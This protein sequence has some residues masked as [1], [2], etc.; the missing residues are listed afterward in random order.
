MAVMDILGKAMGKDEAQQ[1]KNLKYRV[2]KKIKDKFYMILA[3]TMIPGALIMFVIIMVIGMADFGVKTT[4]EA[5]ILAVRGT[6]D[7]SEASSMDLLKDVKGKDGVFSSDIVE[8]FANIGLKIVNG[9]EKLVFNLI[10][11]LANAVGDAAGDSGGSAI[12]IKFLHIWEEHEGI[13]NNCYVV[14]NVKGNATV[15]YGVDLETSGVKPKVQAAGYGTTDGSLIPI[16]FVDKLELEERTSNRQYVINKTKGLGLKDYQIDALCAITYQCGNIG[17]F[18]SAYKKYGNTDALKSAFWTYDRH[19]NKCKQ[20]FIKLPGDGRAEANWILFHTGKYTDKNKKEI[21]VNVG[22]AKTYNGGKMVWPTAVKGY[23]SSKFGPRTSPYTGYHKG[24]DIARTGE[25][26]KILAAASG[27]VSYVGYD[28]DGY[29]NYLK[30][31]HGS[32]FETR[33]AHASKILVKKGQKV[34]AGDP[35]AIIGSTGRST[36]THLH[37]EV[38]INGEPVNPLTYLNP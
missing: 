9:L 28:S 17:N 7:G 29:G 35:I 4:T 38:R 2:I 22:S 33:Y 37:F 15:G 36:G 18:V 32:G 21:V 1:E 6:D 3:A 23:I 8:F 30:I 12:Y 5:T 20:P 16:D 34:S 13:K 24:I 25:G 31:D 11:G 19:G 10:G 26:V 14:R 27:T